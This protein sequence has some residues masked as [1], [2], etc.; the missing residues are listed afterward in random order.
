MTGSGAYFPFWRAGLW[1]EWEI[2]KRPLSRRE[3]REENLG[4]IQRS[5]LEVKSERTR[6]GG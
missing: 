5:T 4:A 1:S 6:G 3:R 2:W